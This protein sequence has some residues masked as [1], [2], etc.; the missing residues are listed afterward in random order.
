MKAMSKTPDY[1]TAL[2]RL[3]AAQSIVIIQAD[4]P[5]GDSLGSAL[6]L[7]ALLGV[8]G[9]TVHLYCSVDIPRYL[10]H[11]N[12][13]D[14]VSNILPNVFDLAV[15]VDTS[16]G[17]LLEKVFAARPQQKQFMSAPLLVI[18]HHAGKL[19]IEHPQLVVLNDTAAV[20]TAEVVYELAKLGKWKLDQAAGTLLAAG[21]LSDSL[22]LMTE[23]TTAR[24]IYMLAELVDKSGVKLHELDSARREGGKKSIDILRYKAKLIERIEFQ[25]NNRLAFVTIP[26]VEI[27]KFSDLYNPSVL[28]LEELRNT[29]GVDI[30]VAV[31]DYGDRLTGKLRAN[32]TPICDQIAAHFGGGGHPYAAGFK[33]RD[34]KLDELKV[35]LIKVSE[36]L[37][38]T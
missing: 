13:W 10:R 29:E 18:D 12:G 9:K 4:N 34:L 21:L 30:M 22:G 26:L 15:I 35:E 19:S 28:V 24:S 1:K 36:K 5:D 20:A 27:K 17:S 7:E 31:K 37:L 2:S 6:A 14:R 16:A 32:Y 25:L 38:K 8:Q 23:A 11:L 3:N 33:T